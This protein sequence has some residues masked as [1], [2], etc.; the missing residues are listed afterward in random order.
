MIDRSCF[1]VIVVFDTTCT[2]N[3]TVCRYMLLY[4]E[5]NES[6]QL[7]FMKSRFQISDNDFLL[8]RKGC[9]LYPKIVN[10]DDVTAVDDV[11]HDPDSGQ[12]YKSVC[13]H[14]RGTSYSCTVII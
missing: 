10:V 4:C 3:L 2:A 9:Y 14:N 12:Y 13:A 5:P 8:L 11:F 6:K 1:D 7:T